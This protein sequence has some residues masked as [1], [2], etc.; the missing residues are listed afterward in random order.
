[1]SSGFV[2]PWQNTIILQAKPGSL[3]LSNHPGK[4]EGQAGKPKG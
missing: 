3:S 2:F 4:I 1:M